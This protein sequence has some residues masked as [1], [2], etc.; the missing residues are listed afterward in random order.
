MTAAGPITPIPPIIPMQPFITLPYGQDF[1]L[2][3]NTIQA[4]RRRHQ[5]ARRAL[6][7]F[8]YGLSAILL[9]IL[10]GRFAACLTP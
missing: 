4:R 2:E 1:R 3:L 5:A 9:G 7:V 6:A 10:F 8:C